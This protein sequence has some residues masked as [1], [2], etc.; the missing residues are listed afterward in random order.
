MNPENPSETSKNSL[1]DDS[2]ETKKIGRNSKKSER[3]EGEIDDDEDDDEY[4]NYSDEEEPKN[5]ETK[6]DVQ[7]T[8]QDS[9]ESD[10]DDYDL[11]NKRLRIDEG[12]DINNSNNNN[13]NNNVQES[14]NIEPEGDFSSAS[15]SV[16]AFSTTSV[17]TEISVISSTSLQTSNSTQKTD[18][19]IKTPKKQEKL[20]VPPLKIICSNPNGGL[21][22]IKSADDPKNE[23]S[24]RSKT[25]AKTNRT[26]SPVPSSKTTPSRR[27]NNN[28]I[29]RLSPLVK[30]RSGSPSSDSSIPING[31]ESDNIIRRKLRSHTRLQQNGDGISQAF[32]SPSSS[33]P[34]VSNTESNEDLTENNKIDSNKLNENSQGMESQVSLNVDAVQSQQVEQHVINGQ[35]HE[36]IMGN[37]ASNC[38]KKFYQIRN[39]VSKRRTSQMQ[40]SNKDKLPKNLQEFLLLRRNYLIRQNKEV[41]QSIPILKPPNDMPEELKELF[42]KQEKERY[43]LRLRHKVEQD[44]L[45]I[46]Y[47]QEILRCFNKQSINNFNQM[48]PMSFCSII[49]DAE[50][51]SLYKNQQTLESQRP[52][53]LT[54]PIIQ[55]DIL[56]SHLNDI[57]QKFLVFKNDM[58]KRQLNESDALFAVQKMAFQSKIRDLSLNNECLNVPIV[59]VNS[60]F[61]L[62]DAASLFASQ[63]QRHLPSTGSSH[64]VSLVS[65]SSI[66]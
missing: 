18:E 17:K 40:A 59:N 24:T 34:T 38:I 3:E 58:I 57:K 42:T 10:D 50:V 48:V 9:Y 51:Y 29:G 4:E 62:F 23:I 56:L 22:Y 25:G 46:L 39:E 16:S 1:N 36:L 61:E 54:D 30:V 65:L 55:E 20:K 21:P 41:R 66:M 7:F 63:Q 8:E 45:I 28:N 43:K 44:K 2:S 13:I 49:K 19:E 47:E 64:L 5:L 32:K 11:N 6:Q 26:E 52:N 53:S 12:E 35:I 33:P 31:N 37:S 27:N 15:S 14:K 60:K